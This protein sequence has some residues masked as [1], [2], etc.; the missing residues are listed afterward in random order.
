MNKSYPTLS[1]EDTYQIENK[2]EQSSCSVIE[3]ISLS[4]V[5]TVTSIYVQDLHVAQYAKLAQR[6]DLPLRN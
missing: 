4:K 6:F 5:T 1:I 3:T 2:G